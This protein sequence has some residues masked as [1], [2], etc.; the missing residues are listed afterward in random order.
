M[1]QYEVVIEAIEKL[2]G[3]ATLGQIYQEALKNPEFKYSGKT[4]TRNINRIVQLQTK[5]IY[6]IKPGLYSLVKYRKK[7]ESEG[8]IV[9]TA[10]NVNSEEVSVFNHSYYQGILLEIG[11]LRKYQTFSP[12][13]DKNK[14]FLSK[15]IGEMRTLDKIPQFTYENLVSRSRTVDVI[16]FN[17]RKMPSNFFEVEHTTQFINSLAKFNDLQDFSARMIIVSDKSR[18]LEF[19]KSKDFSSFRDITKR[20]EFLNYEQLIKQYEALNEKLSFE[21]VII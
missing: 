9:E 19:D 6:K 10:K 21:T 20:V 15:F 11:N 13:Q 1:K 8:I 2:G 7:N 17:E 3:I 16:W 12:D 14:K 4:P 5:D 18:K